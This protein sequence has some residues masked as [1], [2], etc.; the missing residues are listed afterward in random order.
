MIN[1][2][3]SITTT[4]KTSMAAEEGL[5]PISLQPLDIVNRGSPLAAHTCRLWKRHHSQCWQWHFPFLSPH[6]AEKHVLKSDNPKSLA[7][8]PASPEPE[9]PLDCGV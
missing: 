7:H 8:S 4:T 9:L 5:I 6:P 3:N 2:S 1:M